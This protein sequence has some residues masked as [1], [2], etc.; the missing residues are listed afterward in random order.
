MTQFFPQ[1]TVIFTAT[2]RKPFASSIHDTMGLPWPCCCWRTLSAARCWRSM[3]CAFAKKAG[4]RSGMGPRRT[5]GVA[6]PKQHLLNFLPLPHRHGS[7]LPLFI[8]GII[9]ESC[10]CVMPLTDA[11]GVEQTSRYAHLDFCGCQTV[12][13]R[14]PRASMRLRRPRNLLRLLQEMARPKRFELLT[15]RFVVKSSPLKS[16]AIFANYIQLV[17]RDD[18]GLHRV[19]KPFRPVQA[20]PAI[21]PGQRE[22]KSHRAAPRRRLLQRP[23]RSAPSPAARTATIVWSPRT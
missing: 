22:I 6:A 11:L 10:R 7:F 14:M 15:P 23:Q 18:N 20:L 5:S 17:T 1:W 8:F 12:A 16:Q 21:S 19:C 3:A 4:S 9:A 2:N 13:S